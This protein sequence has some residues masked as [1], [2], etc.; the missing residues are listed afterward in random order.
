VDVK[1]SKPAEV[2]LF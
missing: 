2:G 1:L